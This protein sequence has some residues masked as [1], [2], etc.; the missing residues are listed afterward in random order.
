MNSPAAITKPYSFS[1]AGAVSAFDSPST[2]GVWF[3]ADSGQ[4]LRHRPGTTSQRNGSTGM[5]SFQ[6]TKRPSSG[7]ITSAMARPIAPSRETTRI[8]CHAPTGSRDGICV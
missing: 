1:H 6:S 4:T 7:T 5:T 3:D 2:R 8:A